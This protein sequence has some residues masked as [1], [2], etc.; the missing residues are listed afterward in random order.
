ME[1]VISPLE[2]VPSVVELDAPQLGELV[3]SLI[4][5]EYIVDSGC[6]EDYRRPN[7]TSGEF[8]VQD[9]RA[10]SGR[11]VGGEDRTRVEL[12]ASFLSTGFGRVYAIGIR[13][14]V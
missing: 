10:K 9:G 13:E 4:G 11:G 1:E 3:L 8:V 12:G 2:E 7:G 14:V 6:R 5:A